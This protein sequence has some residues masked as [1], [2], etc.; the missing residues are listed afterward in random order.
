M[1]VDGSTIPRTQYSRGQMVCKGLWIRSTDE[2]YNSALMVWML[3]LSHLQGELESLIGGGALN[4][5][6]RKSGPLWESGSG[7]KCLD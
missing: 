6:V 2:L 5:S 1:C 4:V 3:M 7:R